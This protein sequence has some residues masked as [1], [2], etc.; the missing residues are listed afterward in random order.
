MSRQGFPQTIMSDNATT[1]TVTAKY[2]NDIKN[3]PMVTEHM[4]IN[5]C[6]WRFI[7]ARAPWF[8]A[9]WERLIGTVKAGLR[10]VLGRALGTVEELHTIV[11]EVKSSINDRP[12]TYVDSDVNELN[13]ITPSQ[14]IRGRRLSAFHTPLV[15]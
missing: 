2:L 6:E 12:L 4:N 3:D 13:A 11:V 14:L 5:Q 15:I 8:G 9:I 1:F 10:K 7:P